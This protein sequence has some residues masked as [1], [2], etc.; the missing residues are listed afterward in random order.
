MRFLDTPGYAVE[1]SRL[2]AVKMVR[3]ARAACAQSV[4]LLTDYQEEKAMD[5]ERLEELVDH[6]EDALGSYLVELS[7]R[8]QSE[9]DSRTISM[10]LH[11]IGDFERISDHAVNLMES[12]KELHQKR[13]GFSPKAEQELRVFSGALL[14]IL[15]RSADVFEREDLEGAGRSRAY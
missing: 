7:R 6:Y 15:E 9:R 3:L 5:V 10:L 11:C 4:E 8:D 1:L 14:E 12:A 13:L 2:A